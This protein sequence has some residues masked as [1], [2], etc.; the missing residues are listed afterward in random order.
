MAVKVRPHK[1]DKALSGSNGHA[2]M[3]AALYAR[4]STEEQRER[5]SIETQIDFAHSWCKQAN[6]SLVRANALK[7]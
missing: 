1:N 5:Q 3:R 7:V 4:V 2:P 6:I